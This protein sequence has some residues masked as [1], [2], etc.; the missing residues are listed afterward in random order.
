MLDTSVKTLVEI[1][2][3]TLLET[4][5]KTLIETLVKTLVEALEKH[6]QTLVKHYRNLCKNIGR[7]KVIT[8]KKTLAEHW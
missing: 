4:P 5:A 3:V 2:E 8:L 7:S 1:L 6:W